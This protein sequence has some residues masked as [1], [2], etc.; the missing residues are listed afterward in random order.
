MCGAETPPPT[1]DQLVE[2]AQEQ[3]DGYL[4]PGNE[5]DQFMPA[6]WIWI[7]C[8]TDAEGGLICPE[9][10]EAQEKAFEARRRETVDKDK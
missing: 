2:F 10:A 1:T 3:G 4:W 6:G 9:C 8:Q 7:T 5:P